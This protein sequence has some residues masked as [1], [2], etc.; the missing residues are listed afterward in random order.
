[1][2]KMRIKIKQFSIISKRN[3]D[4]NEAAAKTRS[5]S[6]MSH[7]IKPVRLQ[8]GSNNGAEDPG[9]HC[10]IRPKK[11]KIHT[12][13]WHFHRLVNFT[14]EDKH[15]GFSLPPVFTC[16]VKTPSSCEDNFFI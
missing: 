11:K 7:I 2:Q 9:S 14:D 15:W 8:S 6:L 3:G 10:F 12:E 5:L 13:L 4:G 1:M 16:M